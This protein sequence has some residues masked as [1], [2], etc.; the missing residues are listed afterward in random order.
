MIIGMNTPMITPNGPPD[1]TMENNSLDHDTID[2]DT[3]D[4]DNMDQPTSDSNQPNGFPPPPLP[5]PHPSNALRWWQRP[6]SRVPRG[7][8]GKVGGVVSGLSRAFG[9]DVRTTR[10][11]AVLASFVL[12]FLPFVYVVLWL[13]LPKTPA[14]AQPFA[15]VVRDRRRMPLMVVLGIVLVAAGAGS[16]G[17]WFVFGG[18]PLGLALIGVGV[19]LWI[20]PSLLPASPA[21][22]QRSVAHSTWSAPAVEPASVPRRRYPIGLASVGLASLFVAVAAAL[23]SANAV[24]PVTLTI[25]IIA[26]AIAIGGLMISCLVNRSIL[27]LPVIIMFSAALSFLAVARPQLDGGVGERSVVVAATQTS[28]VSER[29]GIG[30]LTIDVAAE[31]PAIQRLTA[32]VGIGELHIVVPSSVTLHLHG[33]VGMGTV[34]L[35]GVKLTDGVHT[36]FER[37]I[38]PAAT[39][40]PTSLD[41]DLTVGAGLISIT[42][43]P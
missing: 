10:I 8:G 43:T 16:F 6:V 27:A 21:D 17:T 15:T 13:L 42:H 30:R 22:Q 36:Q 11:A 9:F 23:R 38:S 5:P 32:T 34:E 26:L 40:D 19:L 18:F 39:A 24:H 29:L 37:T 4:H 20:S 14:E 25:A 2:H 1:A 3:I 35:D 28:P 7:A 41:L 12:P 31:S 33:D